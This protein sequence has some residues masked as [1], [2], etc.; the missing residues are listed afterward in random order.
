MNDPNDISK[1]KIG[2]IS[3]DLMKHRNKNKLSER[4]NF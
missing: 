3:L 4:L 2:Q 1:A